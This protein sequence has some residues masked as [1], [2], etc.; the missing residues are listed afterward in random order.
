MRSNSEHE[1]ATVADP[2][3]GASPL[4]VQ[5]GAG[6]T[7]P[8]SPSDR[9]WER[10]GATDPY[11]GVITEPRFRSANLTAEDLAAFFRSGQDHVD[12]VVRACRRHF[13]SGFAPRS[14]FDF[15]C[16]VGRALIPFARLADRVV[17]LDVSASMIAEAGRNV[18]RAGL[19]NVV[20]VKSDGDLSTVHGSF[21]LV[22][23]VIVLQHIE[24]DRGMA[25]IEQLVAL[26]AQDGV[27]A[28]HLTYGKTHV[29]HRYGQALPP[30]QPLPPPR[31]HPV[32]RLLAPIARPIL[33][34]LRRML[35]GERLV[36]PGIPE[37]VPLEPEMHMHS[38]SLSQVFYVLQ[39]CGAREVFAEFTDHGGELGVLLYAKRAAQARS[40]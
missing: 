13:G 39:A 6:S 34:P 12:A 20:L 29:P 24:V 2:G 3:R 31:R 36:A 14:V 28:L 16:G 21:D 22:H 33:R 25:L 1:I 17:G 37:T 5:A 11:F 18:R 35:D 8:R 9:E 23:S 26:A 19:D 38:Y 27:L 32:R 7:A 10:W 30:E 40:A 15:G 4:E